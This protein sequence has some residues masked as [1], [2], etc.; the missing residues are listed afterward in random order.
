M[1]T[2]FKRQISANIFEKLYKIYAILECDKMILKVILNN[3]WKEITE[4]ILIKNDRG[5]WLSLQ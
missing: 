4:K 1:A 3:K 2:K 5:K